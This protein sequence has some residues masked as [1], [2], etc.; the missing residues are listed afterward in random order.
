MA[1]MIEDNRM[2]SLNQVPW[3]NLGV[4]LDSPPTSAEAIKAAGMAWEVQ[5]RK[6]F[7]EVP[8]KA[9][10]EAGVTPET[11]AV[12]NRVALV[13]DEDEKLLAVVS[14]EYQVLQNATAF[15]WFDPIVQAGQATYETAGV[16]CEGRKIWIMARLNKQVVVSGDEYKQYMLLTNGHDGVTGVTLSPVNTRVVCNNTMR[17]ALG[18]GNTQWFTH[19]GDMAM[20]LERAKEA[21]NLAQVHLAEHSA[22][23]EKFAGC[24]LTDEQIS[25]ILNSV[26]QIEAQVLTEQEIADGEVMTSG[27]KYQLAMKDCILGLA[28]NADGGLSDRFKGTAYGL[29]NAVTEF[30]DHKAGARS[31]DRG[32]YQLFGDGQKLKERVYDALVALV[33]PEEVTDI[34]D[35]VI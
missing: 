7:W 17:I 24:K 9:G 34:T 10:S 12:A 29:F 28:E 26:L 6:L 27:T 25:S 14:P 18:E 4:V 16:M 15:A 35:E 19:T 2:F 31:K 8:V 11:R 1:H 13:R 32:N 21:Y 5:K 3:H 33:A 20:K 22:L 30:V 23:L